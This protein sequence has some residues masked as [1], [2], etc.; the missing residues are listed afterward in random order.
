MNHSMINS[1][2]SMHALQQKLDMLSNNIANINTTGYKR[3]EASF[4]DVLTSVKQQPK[5]F[6]KEGRLSPL[7]YNQGWGSRL[8]QAQLNMAQGSLQATNSSLD[9]AIEGNGLFEI[10]SF[11]RDANNNLVPRTIWSRNGSFELTPSTDPANRD[12]FLTT[13]DGQYVVGTDNNPIRVPVDHRVQFQTD[14]KVVAYSEI[15]KLAP[16]IDVGQIK[17]VRVIRPQVLQQLGDNLYDLPN[18]IA[19]REDVLQ[20]LDANN[21]IVDPIRVRQG[22]LENSNVTLAD[23]MTDLLQVQRAFQLNSRA[24]TSSDTMMGIANNLRNG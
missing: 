9:L 12:M 10:N 18:G 8:V 2:V 16:P 1:S 7:G 14:G 20:T 15:D 23:E 17:L 5:G 19:N 6:E 22:F 13:K 24:V 4:Q 21:N 11:T 3:K